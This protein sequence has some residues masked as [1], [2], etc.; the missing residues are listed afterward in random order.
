MGLTAVA[1]D[2]GQAS[3]DLFEAVEGQVR[4]LW[5]L[6][7]QRL[8]MLRQARQRE[9]LESARARV[10]REILRDALTGLGNRRRFDVLVAE[11]QK[12]PL[13]AL[14]IDLDHFKA[15]ND[16]YSHTVG[17]RVLREVA[18]VLRTH[19]RPGDEAVRYAGDEFV[20]FLRCEPAGAREV[21]E[22]IRLAV[23]RCD[24]L[25]GIRLTVSVGMATLTEGMTGEE[26][27][28][29]ADERL[30]AAKFSGRNAVAA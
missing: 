15:V 28:R 11:E 19:C 5:R 27:F 22:R 18:T 2:G 14:L 25:P 6:R 26:L 23:A 24:I 7:L 3:R 12:P 9:D 1:Q 30:Y 10:E 17:D 29:I 8:S 13:V 20:L 16:A 4:E 21:A